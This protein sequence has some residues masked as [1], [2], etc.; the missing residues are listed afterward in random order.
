M[1]STNLLVFT[2]ILAENTSK[3]LLVSGGHR[4]RPRVDQY[5]IPF[6]AIFSDPSPNRNRIEM[7]YIL[8]SRSFSGVKSWRGLSPSGYQRN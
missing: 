1:L 2:L 3:R 7:I 6:V 8:F 4:T 5:M